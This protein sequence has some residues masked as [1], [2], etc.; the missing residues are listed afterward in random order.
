MIKDINK[1]TK[2]SHIFN[3]TF[4]DLCITWAWQQ[5]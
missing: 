1:V 5:T 3:S 4:L 2:R